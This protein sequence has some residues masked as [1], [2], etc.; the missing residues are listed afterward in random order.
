MTTTEIV[1]LLVLVLIIVLQLTVKFEIERK[2]IK[3][4]APE[5]DSWDIKISITA[6]KRW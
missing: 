6:K 4:Y 2:I 1:L 3:R 5:G